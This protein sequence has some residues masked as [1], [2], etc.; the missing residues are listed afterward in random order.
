MK[1]PICL[2]NVIELS[3]KSGH[4]QRGM[5]HRCDHCKKFCNIVGE[6]Y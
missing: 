4:Y 5:T 6:D 3:E 2:K 1:C